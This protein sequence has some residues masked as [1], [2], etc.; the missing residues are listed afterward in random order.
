MYI[1]KV[2]HWSFKQMRGGC[3]TVTFDG[4]SRPYLIRTE[5]GCEHTTA[6]CQKTETIDGISQMCS[7]RMRTDRLKANLKKGN[8]HK[9]QFKPVEDIRSMFQTTRVPKGKKGVGDL[10]RALASAV[11][12]LNVSLE[13]VLSPVMYKLMQL[14]FELGQTTKESFASTFTMPQRRTLRAVMID[15]AK[16]VDTAKLDFYRESKFISLSIDEGTTF[17]TAYLNIILHDVVNRKNEYFAKSVVMSGKTADNYVVSMHLGFVYCQKRNLNISSVVMD[18]S[19]AQAKAFDCKYPRSLRNIHFTT[20]TAKKVL[21][22]PCACHL[23]ENA[24]KRLIQQNKDIR[25]VVSSCRLIGQLLNQ[26]PRSNSLTTCPRFVSTRW[27]YDYDIVEYLTQH[28]DA[29]PASVGQ[30]VPDNDDL[31]RLKVL[32]GILRTLLA[33]FE[34][35]SSSITDV[36]P[37]IDATINSLVLWKNL[38]G[39]CDLDDIWEDI[40]SDMANAL[41]FYFLE[42]QHAGMLI[43][44]HILTPRGRKMFAGQASRQRATNI[45]LPKEFRFQDDRPDD[46]P[47][48]REVDEVLMEKEPGLS[49]RQ[50]KKEKDLLTDVLAIDVGEEEEDSVEFEQLATLNIRTEAYKALRFVTKLVDV[51]EKK[52]LKAFDAYLDKNNYLLREHLRESIDGRWWNWNH[53][54]TVEGFAEL[55]EI[56]QRIMPT[57][58]SEASAERSISLQRAIILSK[59]NKAYRD[60]VRS[61]E[62][63]MQASRENTT[64]PQTKLAG[65]MITTVGLPSSTASEERD[66]TRRRDRHISEE[67]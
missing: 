31:R 26:L 22:F 56:A 17:K 11:G 44:S 63:L 34:S 66:L 40:F 2:T 37:V 38:Q 64:A 50:S 39:A 29:V 60:L 61:R 14:S 46:E 30:P 24:Y 3:R 12:Q 27:V 35:A 5:P 23:I 42:Q 54:E 58:A 13:S 48:T 45:I 16:A 57:P 1:E 28:R 59:R 53:V 8:L 6:F 7:F 25:D 9:C 47:T 32:L 55:S 43:L 41:R 51:D 62:I 19:K 4:D 36:Y 67:E 65:D 15:E 20:D 21:T 10:T 33:R 52:T 18:G 49:V